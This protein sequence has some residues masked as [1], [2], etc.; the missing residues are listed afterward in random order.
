[1]NSQF[2]DTAS[3][4]VDEQ[5]HFFKFEDCYQIYNDKG[6]TIGLIAQKLSPWEKMLR[7]LLHKSMLPFELEIKNSRNEVEASIT[8]GWT[9]FMSKIIIHDKYGNP[10]GTIRQMFQ[11][12]KPLFKIFNMSDVQVAE[13][14]GDWKA[15]NFVIK[16]TSGVQIGTIT[17]KWAGVMQEVFTSADKYNVSIDPQHSNNENKIAILSSAITIDMVLKSTQK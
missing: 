4:F 6:E 9:F 12:F 16:D 14:S 8:R 3:Y 2:F 10:I 11:F 1:M 5:I 13:I 15:W 7:L 17:K